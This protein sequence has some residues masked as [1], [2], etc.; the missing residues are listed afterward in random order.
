M[1]SLSSSLSTYSGSSISHELILASGL[2]GVCGLRNP[3]SET[4]TGMTCVS[5]GTH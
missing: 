2:G 4:H 5:Y 3:K 1:A